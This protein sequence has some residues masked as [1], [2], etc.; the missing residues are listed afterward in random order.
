[1]KRQQVGDWIE[2]Y[3]GCEVHDPLSPVV[4]NLRRKFR[5]AGEIGLKVLHHGAI[6]APGH[7]AIDF[8]RL[9]LAAAKNKKLT[10]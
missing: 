2:D 1:L 10:D 7:P 9:I 5:H 8:E 4:V 3:L 6:C